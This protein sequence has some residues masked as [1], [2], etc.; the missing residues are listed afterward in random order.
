VAPWGMSNPLRKVVDTL[1]ELPVAI[2]GKASGARAERMRRSPQYADG[3]FHNRAHTSM[4]AGGMRGILR[5][6][7]FGKQIRKPVGTVPLV[8]PTETTDT[9]LHVTWYG[10]ASTLVEL[11]GARVL[12]DP[13]WSDRVSPTQL[14]GPK[15]L[16]Q[17]P[18]RVEDLPHVDAIVISHDHYDHLDFATVRDLVRTQDAPFVV[19]LGVGAHLDRWRV[20]RSRIIELDWN[21]KV[22]LGELTVTATPAQH[23]SG[24]LFARDRTLWTSWLVAAHGRSA[25]YTGDSGYFDGYKTIGEEHGP[26]DV[27]LVQVGAYG[28]GW[29]DIHMTPEQGVATHVDVR[30]G[31]MIPVHWATFVLSTHAWAEP[32]DRVWR[33]AKATD[34]AIA[35]PRPG[36]RVDV[37]SPASIDPWWQTLGH[38]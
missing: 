1:L 9:G 29:P 18:H 16:H 15:R 5:D 28:E 38:A 2:G 3:R 4:M 8:G 17:P 23:F 22:D 12:F 27:T 14:L 19:P 11:G 35:I 20:P 31:L 6:Y 37:D 24:R 34:V 26:V 21:D 25:F 32:A 13:V 36:E 30:G 10:H 33:E 7:L